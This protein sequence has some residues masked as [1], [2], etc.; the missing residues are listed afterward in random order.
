MLQVRDGDRLCS[1]PSLAASLS[2]LYYREEQSRNTLLYVYIG[3]ICEEFSVAYT[4]ACRV[5]LCRCSQVDEE[6]RV[7]KYSNTEWELEGELE[8]FSSFD[9]RR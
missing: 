7:F 1:Q 5:V 9:D 2:T 3:L 6:L 4:C 8:E